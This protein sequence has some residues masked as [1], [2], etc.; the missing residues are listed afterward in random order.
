[1]VGISK[2]LFGGK[3][4]FASHPPR[5]PTRTREKHYSL[6]WYIL[7]TTA[8]FSRQNDSQ[9]I[10]VL[11]KANLI[12]MITLHKLHVTY[13][14]EK[15]VDHSHHNIKQASQD[16]NE[17]KNVPIVS[18]IILKEKKTDNRKSDSVLLCVINFFSKRSAR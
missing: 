14:F 6:I 2:F 12:C 3:Q 5:K 15:S 16:N 8:S 9:Q 4:H 13:R 1:M 18:K 11:P 17:V 7:I 10:A